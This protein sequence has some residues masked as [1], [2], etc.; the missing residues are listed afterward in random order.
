LDVQALQ[1]AIENVTA[2]QRIADDER[3]LMQVRDT[4]LEQ[5]TARARALLEAV[6]SEAFVASALEFTAF[7]HKAAQTLSQTVTSAVDT[8]NTDCQSTGATE[9]VWI[10]TEALN[11]VGEGFKGVLVELVQRIRTM[12]ATLP[13]K[14][15]K[16]AF[17]ELVPTVKSMD[18]LVGSQLFKSFTFVPGDLTAP[19]LC[20][21]VDE[22]L[23]FSKTATYNLAA[24]I[25]SLDWLEKQMPTAQSM[26]ESVNPKTAPK[27]VHLL[28][29]VVKSGR[30]F[31]EQLILQNAKFAEVAGTMRAHM[32]CELPQFTATSAKVS[33]SAKRS[34]DSRRVSAPCWGILPLALLTFLFGSP[35]SQ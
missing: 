3:T 35:M 13:E 11:G 33:L 29:E 15:A 32:Q 31:N 30:Y 19:E 25:E 17:G 16:V 4:V 21:L 7:V 5:E 27:V 14:T 23:A 9:T 28:Q 2:S 10:M 34:S 12:M 26:Y 22:P 24:G 6:Q 20:R 1:A 18:A 8:V